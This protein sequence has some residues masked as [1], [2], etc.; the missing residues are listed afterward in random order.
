VNVQIKDGGETN[1]LQEIGSASYYLNG[2][3]KMI[4][5]EKKDYDITVYKTKEEAAITLIALEA[6]KEQLENNEPGNYIDV[7]QDVEETKCTVNSLIKEYKSI[8]W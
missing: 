6:F 5:V 4:S 7:T 1:R 2:G 8:D 3:F